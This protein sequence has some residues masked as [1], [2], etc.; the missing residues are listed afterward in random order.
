MT[1]S[2]SCSDV[3]DFD[4]NFRIVINF[5]VSLGFKIDRVRFRHTQLS[6]AES[7]RA[8]KCFILCVAIK[9]EIS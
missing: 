4:V 1:R 9:R 6:G 8:I 3:V 2:Y 5:S 7:G